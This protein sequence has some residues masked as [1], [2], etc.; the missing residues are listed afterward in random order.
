MLKQRIEKKNAKTG[1]LENW[2]FAQNFAF[3]IEF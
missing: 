1:V 2:I 3:R